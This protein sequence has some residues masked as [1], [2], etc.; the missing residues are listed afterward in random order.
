[1][2]I[3][4]AKNKT[5]SLDCLGTK[6]K[7]I[8]EDIPKETAYKVAAEFI[9]GICALELP[10]SLL[11]NCNCTYCYITEKW[12]KNKQISKNDIEKILK[13]SVDMFFKI[14]NKNKNNR[15]YMSAWGA[16]PF[17]NMDTLEL[18]VDYCIENNMKFNTSTNGTNNSDRAKKLLYKIFESK[19]TSNLQISVDGPKEIQDK[20]RPLYNSKIS[21]FDENVKF[22]QYIN[23]ISKE[24]GINKRLYHICS[25][26]N[27]HD[28]L[29]EDYLK[30]C[31]F[32]LDPSNSLFVNDHLPM[33]VENHICINKNQSDIIYDTITASLDYMKRTKR[34]ALDY[35]SGSLF[36]NNSIGFNKYVECSAGNTQIAI[37]VD[38]SIYPCHGPVTNTKIKE[39]F[40]IGNVFDKVLDF[41]RI[42]YIYD[43][44]SRKFL[45]SGICKNCPL[46]T[47]CDGFL[48]FSCPVAFCSIDGCATS[49][50]PLR[51]KLYQSLYPTWKEMYDL[52]IIN[53]KR[54]E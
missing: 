29:K 10:T 32:F 21:T 14:E 44:F 48:C 36:L 17:C 2:I 7:N 34:Y 50:E 26:L 19:I 20:N 11:C 53:M 16:E 54:C 9:N 8:P 45:Y 5:Y 39:K 22:I 3:G 12:L 42:I 46:I 28:G 6:I 43:V 49:Y 35:Y 38:G 52:Y 13:A 25:T 4:P 40:L 41:K 27:I 37:D 33:R 30:C 31:E 24:L 1:M 18:I 47:A 51:C 15:F 23:D